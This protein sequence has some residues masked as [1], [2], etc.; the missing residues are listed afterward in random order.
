[1][2]RTNIHTEKGKSRNVKNHKKS[3]AFTKQIE[4][5]NLDID[6]DKLE[7]RTKRK[8]QQDKEMEEEIK[9]YKFRKVTKEEL[10]ERRIH[11]YE[12]IL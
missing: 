10:E 12:Q 5:H 11:S 6:L 8:R 9:Q 1:M 2:S 3:L 4:R 7:R